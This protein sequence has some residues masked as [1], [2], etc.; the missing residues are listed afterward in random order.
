M[1]AFKVGCGAANVTLTLA[2]WAAGCGEPGASSDGAASSQGA[3]ASSAASA[4]VAPVESV[5]P[6]AIPSA[7][8]GSSS[9]TP[10]ALPVP[11]SKEAFCDRAVAL[12]ELNYASCTD[13]QKANTPALSHL[14]SLFNA[15][16]ECLARVNSAKVE[17]H[18]EV[19][20]ACIAAAEARGAK[21]TFFIFDL[22]PACQGVVTGKA[23][24]GEPVLYAEECSNGLSMLKNRCVKPIAK[25]GVC[26]AYWG[27]LL[28]KAADH[29]PC[30]AGLACLMTESSSDGYPAVYHCLPPL[31]VGDRCKLGQEL[32]GAEASCYQGRC[33]AL[34]SVGGE[35]MSLSDCQPKQ[36]CEIKGGVFGRCVVSKAEEG[37]HPTV[38]H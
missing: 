20:A 4:A 13:G 19:A 12:G 37:C 3:A 26:E 33:R 11:L 29:L 36:N 10:A 22:L 21:T 8:V 16:Q 25:H 31:A 23:G 34:V 6:S 14:A 38:R 30:D 27:G 32:C 2:L 35:C 9:A 18:G 1:K 17:F 28:G 15:K 24:A 7:A 5:S